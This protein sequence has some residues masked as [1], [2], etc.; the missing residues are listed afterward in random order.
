MNKKM[1]KLWGKGPFKIND[2]ETIAYVLED[3]SPLLSKKKMFEAIGMQRKGSSR[4]ESPGFIGAINLQK[5]IRPELEE[6]LKGVEFYDGARLISAY[7]AE[8]LVSVC[9]VY[10]EARE[11]GDLTPT[12]KP[13]AQSCEILIRSFAKIGIRALIYEQLG[14]EK[15][16]HPEAFRIL[17]ESYLSEEERKWSK[18]FPDELFYQMDRIYGNEKTT[19]RNRPQYYAKFIR[20]Y[21]YEPIEKGFVLKELDKRNP[22]NDKGIRKGRHHSHTSLEIGLPSIKAQIWQVIGTLKVSANKRK[23]ESNF[24]VLMGKDYQGNLFED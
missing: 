24:A 17:I 19:S 13:I 18:E 8:I 23:F 14:F 6:Q 7:P 11:A 2:L 16:K 1:L 4:S 10:L 3:G 20:K 22:K 15:F 5:Y 12:Q 21:I 9:N